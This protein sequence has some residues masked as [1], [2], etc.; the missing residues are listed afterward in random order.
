M[1]KS[2]RVRTQVGVDKS[3]VVNLDQDFDF[4]EILSLKLSQSEIYT[5]QCSDY[6]VI[7]GRVSVNDGYGENSCKHNK[8]IS[9]LF[10]NDDILFVLLTL[11]LSISPEK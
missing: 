4:L 3:V 9:R 10:I 6:G 5:R 8:S 2:Y 11:L 1:S 7:A